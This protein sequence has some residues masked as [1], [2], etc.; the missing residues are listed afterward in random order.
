MYELLLFSV[1]C[2]ELRGT[3]G[4]TVGS[5]PGRK[6]GH[7][8]VYEF[9]LFSDADWTLWRSWD[10]SHALAELQEV[11]GMVIVVCACHPGKTG[12]SMPRAG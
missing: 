10:R 1:P 5:V 9:G 7:E 4:K 3:D 12:C 8:R 6:R 2:V 11:R